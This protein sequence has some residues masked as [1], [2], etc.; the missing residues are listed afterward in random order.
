VAAAPIRAKGWMII[1]AVRIAAP[2]DERKRN[3]KKK[4]KE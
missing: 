2:V 3:E 1:T 4:G